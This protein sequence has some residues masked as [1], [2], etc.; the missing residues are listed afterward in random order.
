LH[1]II[2]NTYL[3]WIKQF[4]FRSDLSCLLF[5]FQNLE[6]WRPSLSWLINI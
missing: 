4:R 2:T 5:N 6:K 3:P 1:I